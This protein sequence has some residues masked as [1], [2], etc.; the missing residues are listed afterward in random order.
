M[1]IV[2][3]LNKHF[4]EAI[5]IVL[6]VIMTIVMGSQVVAR[7]LFNYSISWTEELTRYLFVWSGFLSI[8]FA[9]HK[10]IAIRI[11]QF[12]GAFS[13]KMKTIIFIIDYVIEFA[14]LHV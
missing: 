6:L 13:K 10:A 4:E 8:G 9:V 1:K 12:I 3:W 5:L 2:N 7:Y 14:F 11:D